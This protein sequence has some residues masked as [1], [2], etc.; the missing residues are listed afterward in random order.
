[1]CTSVFLGG[2]WSKGGASLCEIYPPLSHHN[3][4]PRLTT[5][6]AIT[7]NGRNYLRSRLSAHGSGALA[8]IFALECSMPELVLFSFSQYLW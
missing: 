6:H 5:S 1:M 8:L 2:Q 3:R 4:R 7:R